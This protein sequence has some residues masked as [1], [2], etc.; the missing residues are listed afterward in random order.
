MCSC[1]ISIH[2]EESFLFLLFMNEQKTGVTKNISFHESNTD[3]DEEQIIVKL[4]KL[5]TSTS[6]D[7]MVQRFFKKNICNRTRQSIYV[8]K[9]HDRIAVN[10]AEELL[11]LFSKGKLYYNVRCTADLRNACE[12]DRLLHLI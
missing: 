1:I 2:R 11:K 7:L 5:N 12:D 4:K 3:H 10:S 9:S 8:Y 6:K